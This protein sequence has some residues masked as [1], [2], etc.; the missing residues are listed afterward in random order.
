M[1]GASVEEGRRLFSGECK[2]AAG[3][4]TAASIPPSRLPEI[5]FAGRSNAGKSS[6]LNALV[7]RKAMARVSQSPGRTRQINFFR[8]ADRLM[9]ADLPGYGFARASKAEQARWSELITDYL[10]SRSSLR[11]V[12]LL[13]DARR[14]PMASDREVMKL[15]DDM[16]VSYQ[17]VLTKCDLLSE[18]AL[19][20]VIARV[21]D[22]ARHH[23]AAYAD[24]FATSAESNRGIPELR[25]SLA[26]L[27]KR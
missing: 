22:E 25:A 16:A 27:T 7:G 10:M 11:R 8:L 13:I 9:L 3:A 4:A 20:D 26:A 5:A 24:V 2:F 21:G 14:G 6:L 23:K 18:D 19:N 1:A 15:L 12:V 17:L